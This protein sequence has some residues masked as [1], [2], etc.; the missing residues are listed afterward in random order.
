MTL[1][2][3]VISTMCSFAAVVLKV[4][5]Y[6]PLKCKD[7]WV[8]T[9]FL[10]FF[11]VAGFVSLNMA[12]GLM[13]VSLVMTIRATEALFTALVIQIF[14]PAEGITFKTALALI[15]VILGAGLSAAES[16]DAT[17]V[18]IVVILFCNFCFAFRGLFTK[19]IKEV[20]KS[21]DYS[22]FLNICVI[23]VC[24]QFGMYSLAI[25]Y[26]VLY[27]ADDLSI[28]GLY[29]TMY[30]Y[31]MTKVAIDPADLD[32]MGLLLMNGVTFWMYLQ[33]SWVALGRVDAVTHSVLNCLRRPVICVFGLLQFG[34]DLSFF[35]LC[36][37][38]LASGGVLLYS[39]VKRGE[40]RS[41]LKA[42]SIAEFPRSV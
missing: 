34:G 28:S 23:G 29:T 8:Q 5:P 26:E 37:I 13:H 30:S 16:T 2:Q 24:I 11:F 21:D 27:A 41:K 4:F 20:Y 40:T 32:S 33:M 1:V 39:H 15:P 25:F 18:G 22:L 6:A 10:S 3:L 19:S 38:V 14:R 42:A 35:N 36:G 17:L 7:E 9:V 12:F 31:Y